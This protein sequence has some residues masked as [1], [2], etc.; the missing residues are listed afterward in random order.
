M[1]FKGRK[2]M[3]QI[4]LRPGLARVIRFPSDLDCRAMSTASLVL[5]YAA[6]K[7]NQ[8]PFHTGRLGRLLDERQPNDRHR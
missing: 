7:V 5:L 4:S 8:L 2:P 3:T 6:A 1:G